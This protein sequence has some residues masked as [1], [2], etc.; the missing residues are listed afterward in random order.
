MVTGLVTLE[1]EEAPHPPFV[2]GLLKEGP[3]GGKL[4]KPKL[5]FRVSHFYDK[6]LC[7]EPCHATLPA[8]NP[9]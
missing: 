1:K 8:F 2:A 9:G 3:H 7:M 4:A 5:R 6:S